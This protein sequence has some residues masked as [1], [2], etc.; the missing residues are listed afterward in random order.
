MTARTR[1]KVGRMVDVS[2]Y[3]GRDGEREVLEELTKRFMKEIAQLAGVDDY[4][5]ELAGRRWKHGVQEVQEV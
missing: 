1:L 4:Q 5:P 2:E 3:Y